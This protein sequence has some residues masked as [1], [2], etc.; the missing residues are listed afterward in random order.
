MKKKIRVWETT[1][2][3]TIRSSEA[4]GTYRII[5]HRTD[6]PAEEFDL[7]PGEDE[8]VEEA[9]AKDLRNRLGP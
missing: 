2:T 8:S 1:E 3:V 4:E 7:T 9:V 6:G 5:W